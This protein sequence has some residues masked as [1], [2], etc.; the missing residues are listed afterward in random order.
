MRTTTREK[1]EERRQ[2][3]LQLVR[4]QVQNGSLVIRQMT[5]DERRRYPHP[6]KPRRP[7]L[8]TAMRQREGLIAKVKQVRRAAAASDLRATIE[9]SRPEA[10]TLQALEARIEHLERLLEAVQEQKRS[11]ARALAR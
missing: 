2:A 8:V 11:Q 5:D 9:P 10:V 4:E 7:E 6:A 1:A 3:K